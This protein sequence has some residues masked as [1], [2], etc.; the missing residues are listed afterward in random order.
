MNPLA[1]KVTVATG[2]LAYQWQFVCAYEL[3]TVTSSSPSLLICNSYCAPV[4]QNSEQLGRPITALSNVRWLI[5]D[6]RLKIISPRGLVNCHRWHQC[7]CSLQETAVWCQRFQISNFKSLWLCVCVGWE[8]SGSVV[9]PN[10]VK[11]RLAE[12]LC[13]V[14]RRQAHISSFENASLL[15]P[16]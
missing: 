9:V 12:L 15:Q 13:C 1:S 16:K 6:Y 3:L 8:G 2:V 4:M 10:E 5:V 11:C 14:L 7:K